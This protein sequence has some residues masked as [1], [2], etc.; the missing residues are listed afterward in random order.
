MLIVPNLSHGA[1][2]QGALSKETQSPAYRLQLQLDFWPNGRLQK[3]WGRRWAPPTIQAGPSAREVSEEGVR[4]TSILPPRP[5]AAPIQGALAQETCA[6]RSLCQA[7]RSQ[8]QPQSSRKGGL[9]S[10]RGRQAAASNF[11]VL[12]AFSAVVR[13]DQIQKRRGDRNVHNTTNRRGR[14]QLRRSDA[15]VG[16]AQ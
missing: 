5:I 10:L 4:K 6:E 11:Q 12:L 8:Q 7:G 2:S 9:R 15:F 16:A 13:S 14:H 3:A 1:R